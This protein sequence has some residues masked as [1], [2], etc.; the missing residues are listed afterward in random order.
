MSLL[1]KP[2]WEETKERMCA[3]WA[4]ENFGR[5]A[6]GVM[7]VLDDPP[8]RPHPECLATTPEERWYDLDHLSAC[9][10]WDHARTFYGGEAFPIWHVGY[11]GRSCHSTF[12]GCKVDLDWNTGWVH[13]HPHLAGESLSVQEIP[14]DKE[15]QQYQFHLAQLRRGAVDAL[16]KSIPGVGAFGGCGD[17]LAGMRTTERLLYDVLD[18]PDEIRAAELHLMDQWCDLYDASHEIVREAAQGSTCWFG[19]WSPGKFYASQNDF[20]YMISP[21]SYEQ[22][23]LPALEKQLAFLD[24]SIYHVDGIDAFV[25]V[26]MLC[27]LP[28]LDGLQILPGAGKP[29]PLAYMDV[30]K[31]VQAAGKNLHISIGADQVKEALTE[32]SARGLYL[33]VWCETESEARELLKNAEKWSSDRTVVAP[34]TIEKGS[35]DG[36]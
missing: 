33:G 18:R 7:G 11:P 3:W 19:V 20:S 28:N 10:E 14:F 15:G 29:G 27:S 8:D 9:C 31:K 35:A 4:R 34:G 24:H 22:C 5:C 16:G 26:D 21:K 36:Q 17:T 12:L 30:L 13:P 25:H 2:D 6:V 1:Y 23:F 32:L